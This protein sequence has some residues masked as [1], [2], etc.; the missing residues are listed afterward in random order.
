MTDAHHA[1]FLPPILIFCAGAVVAVPLFRRIGLS[2]VIGYLAA[3]IAIG[4]SGFNLFSEPSTISGVAELGVVLLLF[5]VGLE[6]KLPKLY[7]MRRDIFGLGTAQLLVTAA[8]VAPIAHMLGVSWAGSALIA[9]SLALS[10]TAIALATLEERGALQ[11]PYGQRTFSVLLF[12]DLS[13]I[14]ILATVPLLAA[15]LSTSMQEDTADWRDG[16]ESTAIAIAAIGA[17]V[18]AGRYLLNPLF[19][20]LATSGAREVMTAAALLVVLGSAVLMQTVGMSMG[21]GAFLAGLLLAE[22]NFR[23]QLEADIEPF[24]G[25]LLGLFFMSVG[26]SIDRGLLGKHVVFLL[27]AAPLLVLVKIAIA[28]GLERATGSKQVDALRSA[29]LL[30]PAGEFSFVLLPLALDGGL[31]TRDQTSIATVLAALTMLIGPLVAKGLEI[32]LVRG[33]KEDEPQSDYEESFDGAQGNVLVIGFGRF[34]QVVSQVL[35]ANGTEITVIDR[36]VEMIKSASRFGFR[37]YYGDGTRP[38]VLRAAGAQNVRLIAICVDDKEAA[39]SIV[40]IAHREFPQALLYVRAYDR[41]HAIELMDKGIDFQARETFESAIAFGREA[42]VGL[43]AGEERAFEVADDV[44]RRDTVRLMMQQ[45]EGTMGGSDL[46][47]GAKIAPEPLSAPKSKSR[48][49]S[50][51]TRDVIDADGP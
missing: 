11:T 48:G 41:I 24:R 34:G 33:S 13:I 9:L 16:L 2:A 20:I 8:V 39:L 43:G 4:P 19:R 32:A 23:H 26:M 7:S 47:Y 49:L 25:L 6:L 17:L 50:A 42:L 10:A 51:Q 28:Y 5:V 27:L 14:P 46:L 31:L 30:A 18:L 44:R 12:Q 40:E 22:S 45:A 29:V 3:G 37:I 1:S 15:A 38:D 21:L 36:D 35:L